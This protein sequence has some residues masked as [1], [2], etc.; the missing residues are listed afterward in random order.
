MA[1]PDERLTVA[2]A[3]DEGYQALLR[4]AE[5]IDRRWPTLAANEDTVDRPNLTLIQGGG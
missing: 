2:H 4:V 5:Q 3:P 1:T